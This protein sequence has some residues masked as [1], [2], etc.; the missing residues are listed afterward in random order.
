[1][2]ENAVFVPITL[3]NAV[4]DE[5]GMITVRNTNVETVYTSMVD[6]DRVFAL[7]MVSTTFNASDV[8]TTCKLQQ[9]TSVAGAGVKDLTTA[10]AGTSYDYDTTN[11]PLGV[12]AGNFAILEQRA[13]NMDNDNGFKF[14]RLY[15]AST[16]NTGTDNVFGLLVKYNY[17]HPRKQLQGAAATNSAIYIS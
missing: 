2:S 16:S 9:A 10:G 15:V 8:V 5:Y 11:N 14:V 4:A 12:T 7:V 1:M 3:K 6:Y 17:N 13:E